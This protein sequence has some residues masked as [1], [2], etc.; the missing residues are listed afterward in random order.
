VSKSVLIVDDEKATAW[1]LAECLREEGFSIATAHSAAEAEA[2]HAAH[3]ADLV[4]TDLRLPD[5]NGF[6]LLERLGAAGRAPLAIVV[7]AW[8]GPE[9]DTRLRQSGALAY[10]PKP[11]DVERLKALVAC[12]FAPAG[13]PARPAVAGRAPASDTTWRG[14]R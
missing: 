8:G 3:P 1:A 5:R 6:E 7:S 11:F 2:A 10:L 13:P 4:I 9:I 12:A 14:E